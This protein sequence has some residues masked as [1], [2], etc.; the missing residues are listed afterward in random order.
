VSPADVARAA[1]D[2]EGHI[3]RTPVVEV[4][5]DGRTVLLKL[6]HLQRSGSF[7]LRGATRAALVAH[8]AGAS[9][10]V[11]ASGGNHGVA[12]ATAAAG[13]G[14]SAHVFVPADAPAAKV[15][16]ISA[17]GA[18]VHRVA[19]DYAD[20]A[21]GAAALAGRTGAFLLP[22]FDHPEVIAGQGTVAREVVADRPDC[23]AVVV[24]VGGGGLLAGSL[25]AAAGRPVVGV[26]PEGIPT[27]TAALAAGRAVDV[28]VDSVTASALGARRTG[29]AVLGVL[30]AHRP[31]MTLVSDRAILAARDRLWA[32]YR[33][34]VE[35]AA[36]A[37]LAAL[38][39]ALAAPPVTNAER[40]L[41]G[42]ERPCLILCGANSDWR[43]E[44]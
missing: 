37:P 4:E 8:R 33:L 19:G 39:A 13:L 6:E 38:L 29:D 27:V 18:V 44:G 16:R 20:A 31:F 12:V 9:E 14:L 5:L 3:R 2:L 36:A 42:A 23:D 32:D 30:A 40:V 1:L 21:D 34:A 11:T 17:E 22:A 28:P 43:P 7:K 41:R 26:E 25:L 10:L 35:P 24:A 15:A